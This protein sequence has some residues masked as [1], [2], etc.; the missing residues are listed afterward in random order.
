MYFK[1]QNRNFSAYN[2][3][4][5]IKIK[6][7][8][9]NESSFHGQGQYAGLGLPFTMNQNSFDNLTTPGVTYSP[10]LKHLNTLNISN[11][12]CRNCD[13]TGCNFKYF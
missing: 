2:I 13:V 6:G 1:I 8:Q 3:I 4:G 9:N 12:T 5:G 11:C 7:F 10:K